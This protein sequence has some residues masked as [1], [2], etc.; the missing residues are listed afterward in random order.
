MTFDVRFR[1]SS[2]ELTY[3]LF[4]FLFYFI[5]FNYYY[6]DKNILYTANNINYHLDLLLCLIKSREER[7]RTITSALH[8]V[9]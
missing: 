6:H 9:R 4:C 2:T 8:I 5:I 3:I 1:C 7:L